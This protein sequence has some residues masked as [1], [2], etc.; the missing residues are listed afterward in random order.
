MEKE[1][2][3]TFAS[4]LPSLLPRTIS[5]KDLDYSARSKFNNLRKDKSN[6][7]GRNV[8]TLIMHK[9]C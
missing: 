9:I 8:T 7:F 2:T 3:E 1:S 4:F 5:K 6:L